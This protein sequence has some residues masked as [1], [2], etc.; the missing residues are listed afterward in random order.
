LGHLEKPFTRYLPKQGRILEAGCG[1]GKYVLALRARG[2]DVEGIE[3]SAETVQSVHT[4]LPDLPIQVGDV[5]SLEVPDGTYSGYISLGV[6]EHRQAGPEPFLREAHRVLNQDGVM[7]VSVPHFHP[8]RRAKAR[9]G[10]YQGDPRELSFYQYAFTASEFID[11]VG[12]CGFEIMET[13]S[14]NAHKGI[15]D[16]I[17]FL[18]ERVQKRDLIGKLLW[19]ILTVVTYPS[20]VESNLGHMLMIAA[21]RH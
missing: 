17:P 15:K 9:L 12:H 20:I 14:Y 11:I 5:T 2:Y 1:T 18:R 10:L 16:E 4:I 8:L 6:V 21:R 19:K 7:L 13:F 3:W